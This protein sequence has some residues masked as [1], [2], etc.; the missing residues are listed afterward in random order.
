MP[1]NSLLIW[2]MSTQMRRDAVPLTLGGRTS[3]VRTAFSGPALSLLAELGTTAT[4]RTVRNQK[5]PL[6]D[7]HRIHVQSQQEIFGD[8]LRLVIDGHSVNL[9]G[10]YNTGDTRDIDADAIK[11]GDTVGIT[12]YEDD[13]WPN[14]DDYIDS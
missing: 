1:A 5:M 14:P 3:H 8:E 4:E 11:I 2:E 13:A 9:G 10:F 6:I 7:V 12:L